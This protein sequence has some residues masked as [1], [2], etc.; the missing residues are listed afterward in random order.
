[1]IVPVPVHRGIPHLGHG[2]PG[3]R[4]GLK[5]SLGYNKVLR[6]SHAVKYHTVVTIVTPESS[7]C[8]LGVCCSVTVL[9]LVSMSLLMGS[10]LSLGLTA[11][12][13]GIFP[14]IGFC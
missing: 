8:P 12:L 10:A 11:A 9:P 14:T 4:L 5:L 6:V 2:C 13:R 7:Q 1:M 3:H